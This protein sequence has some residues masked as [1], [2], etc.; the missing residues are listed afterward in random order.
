MFL[1]QTRKEMSRQIK[2][3]SSEMLILLIFGNAASCAP[4]DQ[5]TRKIA[6]V[7][8]ILD[9]SVTQYQTSRSFSTKKLNIAD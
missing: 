8:I 4:R 3:N 1:L 2:E 5:I 7:G 6:N 9:K